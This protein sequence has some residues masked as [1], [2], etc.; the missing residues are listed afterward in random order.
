VSTE[1]DAAI[2]PAKQDHCYVFCLTTGEKLMVEI[3]KDDLEVALAEGGYFD[4]EYR[5]PEEDVEYTTL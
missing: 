1:M 4:G 5:E 3:D 2:V